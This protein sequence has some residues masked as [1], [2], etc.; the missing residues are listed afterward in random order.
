M[1]VTAV[2]ACFV[3]QWLGL[4]LQFLR[5]LALEIDFGSELG[6]LAVADVGYAE[7]QLP[8]SGGHRTRE[9]RRRRIALRDRKRPFVSSAPAAE[10]LIERLAGAEQAHVDRGLRLATGVVEADFDCLH[11]LRHVEREEPIRAEG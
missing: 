3:A 7:Q 9:I 4:S 1:Q 6:S 2:P 10:R 8:F 5:A 11:A